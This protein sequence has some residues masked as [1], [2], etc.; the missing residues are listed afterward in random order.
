MVF[1]NVFTKK[2][3][4]QEQIHLLETQLHQGWSDTVHNEWNKAR[5]KFSKVEEWENELPCHKARMNWTKEGNGNYAFYHAVIREKKKRQLIQITREDESVTTHVAEIGLLAQDYFSNLFTASPYHLDQGV[6]DIQAAISEYDNQ[7]SLSL[8][9]MEETREAINQMNPA[10]SPG[11]DEYTGYFY[12]ACWETIRDDLCAF[13]HD[14]F[15]GAYVSREISASILILIPKIS[16]AR[17][18]GDF[19]SISLGNLSAKFISKILASR[20]AKLL[21][22]IVDDEQ[23]GFV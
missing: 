8:P 9:T 3:E 12:T 1:E 4:L 18:L 6:F 5:K 13:V 2:K 7:L 22:K 21:P 16:E 20:L 11:N 15:K 14:F 23:A 17:H 10:S 19:R